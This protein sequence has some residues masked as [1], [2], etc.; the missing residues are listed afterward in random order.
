[1]LDASRP[2]ARWCRS[3]AAVSFF[4]WGCGLTPDLGY[5]G[6]AWNHCT[7]VCEQNLEVTSNR[8]TPRQRFLDYASGA[9]M[10][11][12]WRRRLLACG[13]V[14][15]WDNWRRFCS[16][17]VLACYRLVAIRFNAF[18][19]R[20]TCDLLRGQCLRVRNIPFARRRS[21]KEGS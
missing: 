2:K 10:G 14:L 12:L 5:P 15:T 17:S 16:L 6:E 9:Y 19:N 8:V 13:L 21:K 4:R 7:A 20:S 11:S 1:M 3:P 18:N